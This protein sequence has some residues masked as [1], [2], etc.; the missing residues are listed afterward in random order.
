MNWLTDYENKKTSAKD[1]IKVINN[2]DS[3]AFAYGTEPRS[4]ATA[5]FERGKEVGGIKLFFPAPGR[6]FP[7]Y[8][9]EHDDSFEITV[10]HVL[11]VVQEMIRDKRGDFLVGSMLWSHSLKTS[12]QPDV[13]IAQLSPPDE[14]GYCSFGTSIWN[15][16]RAIRDAKIVL[17]ELN[18]NYIRTYGDNYVHVSE[19]DYFVEHTPSGIKPGATDMLGRKNPG[20]G[21]IETEI[22]KNVATLV[23][24]G[25]CIEIGVGGVAEWMPRLGVFDDKNDIGVHAENLPPGIITLV[26]KGII[27]GKK[28][29]NHIGKVTSTACGGSGKKDMDF[30]NMNPIFELYES[31][32]ILDTRTIAANDNVVAI[33]SALMVDL[34]GQIAAE[35]IEHT[36][37]SSTGG[38]LAFAI[39]AFLSKQGR[40]INVLPSTAKKGSVSR[41]VASMKPGTIV[42]VPRTLAD[43]I[44]TEYGIAKLKGKTQ[45]ERAQALIS[46]AHPDFR[47]ELKKQAQELYF[48]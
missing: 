41:I 9:P 40:C 1:A 11:P 31:D 34:T 10:G 33:N 42:S 2:G 29:N 28:K 3:V 37:I 43:I 39:G 12:Q 48:T 21:K 6:Y 16:K 19:I 23:K 32:Y 46:I 17:V 20:P 36:M 5:L 47:N 35:S 44:V 25:D 38:Q 8:D 24:D 26:Q 13:L 27:N 18:P 4:L 14:H 30:I 22:A 45:R 15:K 7:W